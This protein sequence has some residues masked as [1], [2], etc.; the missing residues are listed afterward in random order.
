MSRLAA[1][2]RNVSISSYSIL[3][4]GI[5]SVGAVEFL[6]VDTSNPTIIAVDYPTAAL[7]L[8]KLGLLDDLYLSRITPPQI[9]I[10]V[11]LPSQHVLNLIG[12][13]RMVLSVIDQVISRLF[14]G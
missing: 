12:K 14:H 8:T 11:R 1:T 5:R 9:S 3:L 10:T 4:S 13:H 6:T 7:T 2:I